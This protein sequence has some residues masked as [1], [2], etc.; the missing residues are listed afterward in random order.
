M[1]KSDIDVYTAVAHIRQM[2]PIHSYEVAPDAADQDESVLEQPSGVS[3]ATFMSDRRIVKTPMAISVVSTSEIMPKLRKIWLL[4][5]DSG[6][7][8]LYN[9]VH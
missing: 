1:R 4:E 2:G 6:F 7:I 5:L 3:C 8:F 9:R